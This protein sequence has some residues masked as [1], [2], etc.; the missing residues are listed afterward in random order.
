MKPE[1]IIAKII[2]GGQT[3]VDR[4]AFDFA[5]E[6]KIEIGGFVP[7]NRLAEDGRI[8]DKYPN[9]QETRS[10]SPAERTE[11]NVKNSDATLILSHGDARGGSRL[12]REFAEKYRKP[13]L[14][15]D[16][17]L[18]T[19]GEAQEKIRK[20]LNSINCRNLNIAGSR[21]SEDAEIY[22]KT[23]ELLKGVFKK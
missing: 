3:G 12:T 7:K 11:R 13:F 17:L 14:H 20:W 6:N 15:I 9:L 2:S 1:Q 5:I 8:S 10:D 19:M 22:E 4:A 18:S 23:L 21:A 16:F